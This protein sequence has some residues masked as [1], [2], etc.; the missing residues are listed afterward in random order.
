MLVTCLECGWIEA[1]NQIVCVH[2]GNGF[3]VVRR[4]FT[5]IGGLRVSSADGRYAWLLPKQDD[6]TLGRHD[7]HG[8]FAVGLDLS[9]AGAYTYGVGRTHARLFV[10]DGCV[11]LQDLQS[12]NGSR[13][14]GQVVW[15]EN[16][17]PLYLGSIFHLGRMSLVFD[18]A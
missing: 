13:I 12:S 4:D 9:I 2:C 18:I 14:G 5:T 15:P 1:G 7:P 6:I 8:Q 16:P 11:W 17:V 10:K 3:A